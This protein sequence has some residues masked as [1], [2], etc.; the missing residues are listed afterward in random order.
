MLM[1]ATAEAAS[2][3]LYV[4]EN[5]EATLVGPIIGEVDI[6]KGGLGTLNLAPLSQNTYTGATNLYGGTLAL[7]QQEA[8]PEESTIRIGSAALEVRYPDAD[9]LNPIIITDVN[10]KIVST[11]S[12]LIL[13]GNITCEA[14]KA[15]TL[16]GNSTFVF[17]GNNTWGEG[18]AL[19]MV[20]GAI[21]SLSNPGSIKN[22]NLVAKSGSI[23]S[24]GSG[25]YDLGSLSETE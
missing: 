20:G 4:N 8:I 17:N 14:S 11:Q 25:L 7:S 12:Q 22:M 21:L 16:S 3:I 1:G 13:S 15:L 24:L 9:I 2:V 23:L 6:E 19:Q 5:Q 18:C 10:S